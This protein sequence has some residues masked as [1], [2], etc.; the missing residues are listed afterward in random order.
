MHHNDYVTVVMQYLRRYNEF[1]TY[2][3]NL[4]ADIDDLQARLNEDVTPRTPSLSFAPGS[5]GDM[6]SQ[7]ERVYMEKEMIP[8]KIEAMKNKLAEI[9]PMM[10]RLNRSIDSLPRDEQA[11]VR[12]GLINNSS[13]KVVGG[14]I[15][16][17]EGG[18]RK[19]S[20]KILQTLASMMFGPVAS[21]QQMSFVFL[22]ESN[23]IIR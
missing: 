22:E 21:P 5:S 16:L 9:E 23:E 17:S 10:K 13:W 2:I 12:E 4:H 19:K 7:Q 15:G 14:N 3:D 1:K 20:K 18:C 11:I 6:L 8:F